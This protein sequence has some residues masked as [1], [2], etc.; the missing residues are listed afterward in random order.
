MKGEIGRVV[1]SMH[2]KKGTKGLEKW[3]VMCTVLCA[4]KMSTGS[5]N[6][7]MTFFIPSFFFFF[8]VL[9]GVDK[10]ETEQ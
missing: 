7:L 3:S 8:F 10:R 4:K 5:L 1:K 2:G 9:L 6:S